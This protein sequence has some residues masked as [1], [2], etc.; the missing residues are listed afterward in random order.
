M[1]LLKLCLSLSQSTHIAYCVLTGSEDVQTGLTL[2]TAVPAPAAPLTAVAVCT[3][4]VMQIISPIT[5]RYRFWDLML[6]A[7]PLAVEA[8]STQ[9]R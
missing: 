1:L 7:S 6:I 9:N 4:I 3:D 8:S 2:V 5:S